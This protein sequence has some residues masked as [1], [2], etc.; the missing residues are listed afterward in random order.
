MKEFLISSGISLAFVMV[1][2]WSGFGFWKIFFNSVES[3]EAASA[4]AWP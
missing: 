3:T 2:V 4:S 1:G